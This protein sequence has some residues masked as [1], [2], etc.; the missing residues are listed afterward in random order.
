MKN[1]HSFLIYCIK[2]EVK[3]CIKKEVPVACASLRRT[4][5]KDQGAACSLSYYGVL[6]INLN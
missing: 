2:H 4:E 1:S 5:K 6:Y 3:K